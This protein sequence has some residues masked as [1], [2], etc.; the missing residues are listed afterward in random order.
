[1]LVFNL[2]GIDSD[3]AVAKLYKDYS[4]AAAGTHDGFN[5]IRLSPNIYNSE[6]ELDQVIA[7]LRDL[8]N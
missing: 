2:P 5:G 1:M 4:I 7:A 8:R 3:A 6:A